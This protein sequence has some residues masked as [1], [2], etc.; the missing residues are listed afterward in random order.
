MDAD[1]RRE[2]RARPASRRAGER[3]AGAIGEFDPAGGDVLHFDVVVRDES[4]GGRDPFHRAQEPQQQVDR[5]DALVHERT[6]AIQGERPAPSGGIV[7]GLGAP[8]RNERARQGDLTEPARVEGCLECLRAGPEAAGQDAGEHHAG[9]GA[10][11]RQFVATG[12]RHFKRLLDDDVLARA[13]AGEGGGEVVAAGRAQTDD[14]DVGMGQECFGRCAS[15]GA[16]FAGELFRL[17]GGAVVGGDDL[18]AGD[19]GERLRVELGNHAGSP[20]AETKGLYAH[21]WNLADASGQGKEERTGGAPHG[22]APV[23]HCASGFAN[24]R[25]LSPAHA[26]RKPRPVRSQR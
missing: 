12:Q 6:A 9:L 13:G 3:R 4:G 21:A 5:V 2:A 1:L 14:V 11:L 19:F 26:W 10:G 18:H 22:A 24:P 17:R 25:N 16:V 8:P 15:G 20:D 7:V 23:P